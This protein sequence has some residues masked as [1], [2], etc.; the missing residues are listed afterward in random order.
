MMVFTEVDTCVQWRWQSLT[1]IVS[2]CCVFIHPLATHQ[3]SPDSSLEVAACR[4]GRLL[5]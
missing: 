3:V 2:N 1:P 4:N 5:Q